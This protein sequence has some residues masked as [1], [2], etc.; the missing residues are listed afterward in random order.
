[1]RAWEAGTLTDEQSTLLDFFVKRDL[2]PTHRDQLSQ[3]WPRV[4]EYRQLER[5]I[6]VPRR[7]PGVLEAAGIDHPLWERGQLTRPGRTVPRRGLQVLG[8][9]P[10]A[11]RQSGRLQLA[12]QTVAAENPLTARVL[13][14]RL[15][16]H[17]F[18]QGL[19]RTVDNFGRLGELPTHPELLDYLAARFV[20]EE[21]W[22]MKRMLRLLLTSE[23]WQQSARGGEEGVERDGANRW[24]SRMSVRRLEAEAIRD[25]ILAVS[26][27]L[28]L[29]M[30]GPGV[31]VY[32]VSRTEGG[33]A[34]GPLDGDRRRSVYQR[35]R[36]NSF[37]PFLEAFDAPRPATTRGRRDV[38]NVPLQALTMLNDPFVI[39][40][41]AKWG[42][43]VV[44][45]GEA[46][47]Q[48]IG[49][50]FLRAFCREIT[51]GELRAAREYLADLCDEHG[52]A[53]GDLNQ[54]V[55]V[56]QDFAQSIFCLK[57]FL[58]VD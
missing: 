12:E 4:E 43:L 30:Y 15:W 24:L 29:K 45:E 52:V 57:E 54:S 5:A 51:A 44:A 39:D 13:V 56:W 18:G 9:E 11:T 46:A 6:P 58:Y 35:I 10:F 32:F 14:N 23:T 27:Q 40:Q 42:A 47:E 41:S 17:S 34:P 3:L 28:D 50:M 53:A 49:G 21:G 20:R 48:R 1:V 8:T 19:V 22:S 2:L 55:A 33:G 7:V 25:A 31:N 16:Q 37:N 36:R 38:T 26:G